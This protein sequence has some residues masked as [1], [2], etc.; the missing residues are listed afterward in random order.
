MVTGPALARPGAQLGHVLCIYMNA[1]VA[2]LQT[3]FAANSLAHRGRNCHLE[4]GLPPALSAN[5]HFNYAQVSTQ[6]LA[7]K[8]ASGEGAMTLFCLGISRSVR[9]S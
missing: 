6:N 2:A 1:K 4:L 8:G 7:R 3:H 5:T 9:V